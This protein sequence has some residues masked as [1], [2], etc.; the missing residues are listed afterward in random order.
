LLLGQAAMNQQA[1]VRWGVPARTRQGRRLLEESKTETASFYHDISGAWGTDMMLT[2]TQWQQL[3]LCI[4]WVWPV[5][6]I[7]H[8]SS[9][10]PGDVGGAVFWGLVCA[11]CGVR[12]HAKKR[13]PF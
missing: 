7:S 2:A 12:L 5:M 11:F 3:L 9:A 6:T 10:G 1:A 8:Y 4:T 13:W